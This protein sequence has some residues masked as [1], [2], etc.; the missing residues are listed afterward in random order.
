MRSMTKALVLA[1]MALSP[2]GCATLH[3]QNTQTTEQMLA[4]AGFTMKPADTDERLAHLQTLPSGKIV[5]RE[6]NGDTYYV[7]A[8]RSGCKCL[9]A[10]RQPQY[11][12]YRELARQQTMADEA[13]VVSEDTSDFRL[14]GPGPWP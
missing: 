5:R 6:H 1:T 9:Y 2:M 8:D 12:R 4:A 7:Y 3:V 11:D 14:W 13:A 10:G